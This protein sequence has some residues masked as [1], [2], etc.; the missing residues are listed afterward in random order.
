[1]S[2]LKDAPGY[3]QTKMK[4]NLHNGTGEIRPRYNSNKQISYNIPVIVSG[5]VPTK[6]SVKVINGNA[7]GTEGSV[8]GATIIKRKVK[9]NVP[10]SDS[11]QK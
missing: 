8:N 1:M 9:K 10:L 4:R 5:D 3:H 7:F 11:Y 6:D 2:N